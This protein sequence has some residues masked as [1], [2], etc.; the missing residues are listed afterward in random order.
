M[1]VLKLFRWVCFAA[2]PLSVEEMQHAM[3]VVDSP[4][5][6]RVYNL[7]DSDE[8]VEHGIETRIIALSGGL[9][10]VRP[11]GLGTVVQV[12][13]QTVRDFLLEEGFETLTDSK[14][15]ASLEK[16]SEGL[17][18]NMLARSCINYL[19]TDEVQQ[20]YSKLIG[21]QW[22]TSNTIPLL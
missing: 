19:W 22:P 8:Y 16:H 9:I 20:Q 14:S 13:H 7:K 4:P 3:A 17:C 15:S 5:P 21:D 10:E 12:S 11:H 1:R 6:L 2:R 18:H